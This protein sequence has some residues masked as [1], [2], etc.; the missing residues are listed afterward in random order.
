MSGGQDYGLK[1]PSP[2]GRYGSRRTRVSLI[3]TLTDFLNLCVSTGDA[4]EMFV[5]WRTREIQRTGPYEFWV[6]FE[7]SYW[8]G[9]RVWWLGR[10]RDRWPLVAF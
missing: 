3:E 6:A 8:L 4:D 1:V 9:G 5:R 2:V 10:E 7:G